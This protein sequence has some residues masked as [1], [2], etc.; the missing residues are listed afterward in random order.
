MITIRDILKPRQ[1]TLEIA[2]S[3]RESAILEI[4]Q[5]LRGDE[6]VRDW[7]AFVTAIKVGNSCLA[8]EN[9]YGLC[10][11]HARTNHVS[12]MVMAAGRS[13]KGILFE[14]EQ[15]NPLR[16]HTLIVIGVP[17]A[18]AADYL[19][20]IGAIAR[21][22]RSPQSEEALR[23]AQSGEEFIRLLAANEMPV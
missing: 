6:R 15:G 22:F 8:N 3:T 5:L 17:T 9:G 13:A 20:I 1:V 14:P 19:R 16:V 21:T 4:A 12:T 2:A 23:K 7:N 18:L 10:I 11:P